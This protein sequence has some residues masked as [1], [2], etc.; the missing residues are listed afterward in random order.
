MSKE[1]WFIRHAQSHGNAGRKTKNTKDN[2]LT[3]LG[4]RQAAALCHYLQGLDRKPG[5]IVHSSYIRTQETMDLFVHWNPEIDVEQWDVQEFTYLS[6]K[7]YA[8]TSPAERMPAKEVFWSHKDM[9]RRDD[10]TAESVYDLL[11]RTKKSI[12]KALDS[13]HEFVM[14]FTHG[15]FMK[16]I[17]LLLAEGGWHKGYMEFEPDMDKFKNFLEG[18]C[19]PNTAILKVKVENDQVWVTTYHDEERYIDFS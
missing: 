7:T 15:Q 5:L 8:N 4:I 9:F 2:P 11:E 18:A 16:T 13:E 1:I 6:A 10:D 19:I 3:E 17:W 12:T 14:V